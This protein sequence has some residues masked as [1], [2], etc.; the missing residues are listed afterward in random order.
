MAVHIE[1]SIQYLKGVGPKLGEVLRK[2]NI[3]TIGDL[4]EWYPRTYQDQ[5]AGI[6]IASLE[7]N[8]HFSIIAHVVRV[9]SAQ[10]GQ[11]RRKMYEILVSDGQAKLHV[12]IFALLI[13]VILKDF[14]RVKK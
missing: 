14:N 13:G 11:S 7:V 10:M 8:H 4:L 5:H 6:S 9:N 2:R 12:N 3:E 1:T